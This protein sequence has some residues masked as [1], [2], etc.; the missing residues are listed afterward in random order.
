MADGSVLLVGLSMRRPIS[1]MLGSVSVL[2]FAL[3]ALAQTAAPPVATAQT[4]PLQGRDAP[5]LSAAKAEEVVVTAQR[6]QQRLLD[7]PVPVTALEPAVLQRTASVNFNDYLARVPGFEDLSVRDG[8]TQLILRGITTGPQPNSTVGTYVD[9][10]PFGSSSIFTNGG[11]LTPD[12]D[13]SDVQ[14]IEV[15]RGPQGTLYGANSLGGLLKFVTAPPDPSGYHGRVEADGETVD[16]GG[17]GYGLR[18]MVNVPI[19][20]TLAVR[21]NFFNRDDPGYIADPSL[22]RT[23]LNSTHVEGGR[24]S[25]LWEPTDALSIRLTATLQDLRSTG[26]PEE[27]IDYTNLQPL[28]GEY[29]QKRYFDQLFYNRYRVYNGDMRYDLGFATLISS[30]SYSTLRS[31]NTMD[32]TTA[33]GPLLGGAFGIPDF[34]LVEPEPIYQTRFTEEVRLASKPGQYVDWQLGFYADHERGSE[35]QAFDPLNTSTGAVIPLPLLAAVS[36]QSRYTEFA[37][38]G[39]VTFHIRPYIDLLAGLRYSSNAQNYTQGEGGLLGGGPFSTLA[40]TSSDS[41]TTFL[42]APSYKFTPNNLLYA[43][44]AS[45][46]RPGGPNALPPTELAAGVPK[47]FQPDTLVNY[48]IGYKS[49]LLDHRLTLDLSAFYIDWKDVQLLTRTGVFTAEGNGGSA[50]SQ[51]FEGTVTYTPLTGVTLSD[52]FAFTDAHLTTDAPGAGG[53]NGDPLPYVPK[54][55]ENANADYDFTPVDG[56]HSYVGGSVRFVGERA[57]AF[58]ISA[59]PS[60]VRPNMPAYTT[61]DLRAGVTHQGYTLNFTIKNLNNSHGITDLTSLQEDPG[62]N[63]YAASLIEPRT[64]GLAISKQF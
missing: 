30:T 45:G 6:R 43:R 34:G 60:F 12:I 38:F 26:T 5:A 1:H 17:N 27:D 48:E 49:T 33:L 15:L 36:L 52:N 25:V 55:S 23:D 46:Y 35:L 29:E 41:S 57:S 10:T 13:P 64:F 37:G 9:D 42:I 14:R 8:E 50:V 59:L 16:G 47:T 51:G 20:D 7:V 40:S 11:V 62:E 58:A 39:D 32:V 4:A 31:T 53:V 24:A 54:W 22:G 18:A 28:Y 63:P 3:P 44:I 56:W 19:T 2:A 61:V 21:A